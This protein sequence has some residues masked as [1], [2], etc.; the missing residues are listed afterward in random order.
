ME[1]SLS[2]SFRDKELYV[3]S[4]AL[5]VY[6]NQLEAAVAEAPPLPN[7]RHY[8]NMYDTERAYIYEYARTLKERIDATIEVNNI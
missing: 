8:P 4:I 2:V 5:Q 6:A 3:L 7:Y 1:S